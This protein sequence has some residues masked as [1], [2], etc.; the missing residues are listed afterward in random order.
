MSDADSCRDAIERFLDRSWMMERTP[1]PTLTGNRVALNALNIWMQRHREATLSRASALDIRAMLDSRHWDTVSRQFEA[2]LGLVTRF[3]RDLLDCK[4]RPD[5]PIE[6]LIGLE[7]TAAARKRE[8]A[9][10]VR[11][12]KV[13]RKFNFSGSPVI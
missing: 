12:R 6:T 8:A 2:L 10:P 3:Y 11:P 4:S 9:R 7:L 5:D 13:R 1:L